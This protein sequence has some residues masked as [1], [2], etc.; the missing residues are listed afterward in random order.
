MRCKTCNAYVPEGATHCLDCGADLEP[1]PVCRRCG[2]VAYPNARFCRICG[3]V[4]TASPSTQPDRSRE[5]R[6]ADPEALPAAPCPRCGFNVAQGVIYCPSCGT[7]RTAPPP[8]LDRA[9]VAEI[10]SPGPDTARAVPGAQPCPRCGTPPRGSGR[11]CFHC[12][13][14]LGGDIEDVICPRCGAT[15]ILRYAR[16][17]YCGADLPT[18]D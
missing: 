15:N 8:P 5:L 2:T 18:P 4:L 10:D 13:R 7:S 14:F 3:A 12:G 1:A 17:Q 11:F 6:P 9:E 16:C